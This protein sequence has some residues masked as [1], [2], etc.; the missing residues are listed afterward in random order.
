MTAP[1]VETQRTRCDKHEGRTEHGHW[2]PGYCPNPNGRKGKSGEAGASLTAA[3]HRALE[4]NPAR[5]DKLAEA[6]LANAELGNAVALK[7]IWDRL[8]G[9]VTE[10]TET[11]LKRAESNEMDEAAILAAAE[12]IKRRNAGSLG[13]TLNAEAS[14]PSCMASD[15]S[16]VQTTETAIPGE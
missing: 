16:Q 2:I 4:A 14:L 10:R 13:S 9:T 7:Q 5:I 15:T 1:E 8:D 6:T 12:A 3:L 11:L